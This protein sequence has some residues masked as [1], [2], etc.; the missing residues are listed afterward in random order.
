MTRCQDHTAR[1]SDIGAMTLEDTTEIMRGPQQCQ[2]QLRNSYVTGEQVMGW[3]LARA[4]TQICSAVW[5]VDVCSFVLDMVYAQI[6]C[7]AD[8]RPIG[9]GGAL[10]VR[11]SASCDTRR[12]QQTSATYTQVS[13]R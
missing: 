4:R 13:C 7:T 9:V 5:Y 8:G 3:R 1:Y 10:P 6:C 12:L 11:L 2:R